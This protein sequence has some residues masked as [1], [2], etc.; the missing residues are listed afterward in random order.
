[1]NVFAEVEQRIRGALQAMQQDGELSADLT[2]GD[3]ELQEARDPAHGDIACNVAMV[4]AKAAGAK[5][6]TLAEQIVARLQSD[7]IFT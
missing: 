4:L 1:M 6:R 5:P 2:I 7:P 3:I